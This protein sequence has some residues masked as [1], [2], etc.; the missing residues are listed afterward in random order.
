MKKLIELIKKNFKLLIRS[1]FSALII[2]IGPI[3]IMLL[4]GLAFSNTNQYSI[5]ITTFSEDYNELTNSYI[6]N[7]EENSFSVFQSDSHENCI[8]SVKEGKFHVC[9]VFPKNFE[10]GTSNKNQIDFYVDYSKINIVY[11]VIE[12]VTSQISEST[13]AISV[14][15]TTNILSQIEST[16]SALKGKGE[17]IANLIEK[18][19]E[20]DTSLDVIKTELNEVDLSYDSNNF[21]ITSLSSYSSQLRGAV[22]DMY[23]ETDD[24]VSE[25]SDTLIDIGADVN[26]LTISPSEKNNIINQLEDINELLTLLDNSTSQIYNENQNQSSNLVTIINEID[27][28]LEDIESQ[29][30]S[31]SSART[32]VLSKIATAKQKISTSRVSLLDLQGTINT[33]NQGILSVSLRDAEDIVNPTEVKINPVASEKTHLNYFFPSLLTLVIMFVSIILASNLVMME[34]TSTAHMRNH[35]TPT[36]NI[37]FLLSNYFTCLF[38]MLFQIIILLVI[39]ILLFKVSIDPFSSQFFILAVLALIISTVFIFFGMGI[40]YLFKSRE[41][42]T[43]GAVSFSTI[44]FILSDVIV[45]IE[46]I[47]PDLLFLTNLNPFMIS[48]Q[49]FRQAILF[50]KDLTS[51]GPNIYYILIY[52]VI[53]LGLT[54]T[55]L[56]RFRKRHVRDKLSKNRKFFF[57]F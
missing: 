47:P 49:L 9:I 45:P 25:V 57:F 22:S 37:I 39:S 46:S 32:G 40:G 4:A 28:S 1:K 43:L 33:I 44:F 53:F 30:G 27:D 13:S 50:G 26:N 5:S 15:L 7:L 2:L 34:K 48:T 14:N 10:I 19:S 42:S 11:V 16:E 55:S 51:L 35:I 24:F 20:I 12:S 41:T 31:A 56:I 36:R 8:N 17:L 18:N 6:D 21:K 54:L 3:L 52:L 23:D 29:L 38:I